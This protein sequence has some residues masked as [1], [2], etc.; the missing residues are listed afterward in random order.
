MPFLSFEPTVVRRMCPFP[1]RPFVLRPAG[2][3][4]FPTPGVEPPAASHLS[5]GVRQRVARRRWEQ[6][7]LSA[8]VGSVNSLCGTSGSS[9]EI[10]S[11]ATRAFI[12]RVRASVEERA[13]EER[14]DNVSV[15]EAISALLKSKS[16]Y[17]DSSAIDTVGLASY[18]PGSVSLPDDTRGSPLLRD[19]CSGKT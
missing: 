5:R 14:S 7:S 13:A 4:A 10:E 16:G 1:L 3:P 8:L 12:T 6:Q 11:D 15:Q 17:S 19:V 2:L 9:A 18:E